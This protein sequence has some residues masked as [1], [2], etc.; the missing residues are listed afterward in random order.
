MAKKKE[1][2]QSGLYSGYDLVDGRY[3]IAP[4]Y[5]EQFEGLRD[6]R[7]ALIECTEMA[8]VFARDS[9]QQLNKEQR[10]L[11]ERIGEDLGMDMG[12]GTPWYYLYQDGCLEKREPAVDTAADNQEK[13][14]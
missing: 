13:V 6:R 10:R 5:K 1:T 4:M 2:H 14:T 9:L 11:F 12:P 8:Q 3:F 7:R